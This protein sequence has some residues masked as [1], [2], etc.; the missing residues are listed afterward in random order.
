MR[1]FRTVAMVLILVSLLAVPAQAQVIPGSWE[2]IST[3]SVETSITVDFKNGDQIKGKFGKL[4]PSEL[5]L[6]T[7]S[8]QAAIPKADIKRITTRKSDSLMDGPLIGTLIGGVLAGIVDIL[9]SP[10]SDPS[11]LIETAA[12]AA[13]DGLKALVGLGIDIIK[14]KE[15][16]LYQAL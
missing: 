1:N 15:V 6:R 14:K 9:Q 3:L 16:V 11:A 12:A 10:A 13:G 4:S 5:F 2:K 7:G 8:A